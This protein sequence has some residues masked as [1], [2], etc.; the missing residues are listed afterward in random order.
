MRQESDNRIPAPGT[1]RAW[2]ANS[3]INCEP[4]IMQYSLDVLKRIVLE[5]ASMGKTFVGCILFE[6]MSIHK[7]VQFV[8]NEMVGFETIPGIEK[9]M[10]K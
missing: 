4:G 1:I 5:M 10:P 3:D 6:E 8:N 2:Y 9:K 7:M